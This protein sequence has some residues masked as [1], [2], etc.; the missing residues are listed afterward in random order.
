MPNEQAQ[1]SG[2][3]G[4]GQQRGRRQEQMGVWRPQAEAHEQRREGTDNEE[5]DNQQPAMESTVQ[6]VIRQCADRRG[7]LG[8]CVS[9]DRLVGQQAVVA[10]AG[11][12]EDQEQDCDD[13]SPDKEDRTPGAVSHHASCAPIH[14]HHAYSIREPLVGR[15]RACRAL[16]DERRS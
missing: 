2:R 3:L 8:G 5:V 4:W 10:L 7:A 14:S 13:R 15:N 6:W 9:S 11:R 12:R 1:G 16:G